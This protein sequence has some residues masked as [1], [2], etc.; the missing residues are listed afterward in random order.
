MWSMSLVRFYGANTGIAFI[1]HTE[2]I[3]SKRI[4]NFSLGD[5]RISF[6]KYI[7]SKL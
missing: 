3:K 4:Y 7:H 1:C 2:K 6:F 5:I